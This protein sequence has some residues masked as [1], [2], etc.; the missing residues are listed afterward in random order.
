MTVALWGSPGCGKTTLALRMAAGLSRTSTVAVLFCDTLVP[1]LPVILPSAGRNI[2]SV[3]GALSSVEISGENVLRYANAVP[4][5][6]NVVLFGFAPG[7]NC[8]SYPVFGE[9]RAASFIAALGGLCEYLIIDCMAAA[10]EDPL[11]LAA[12][13]VSD[14]VVRVYSPDMSSIVFYESNLRLFTD[15]GFDTGRHV[16]VLNIPDSEIA[17]PVGETLAGMK[18]CD[19]VFPHIRAIKQSYAEGR[20]F[21]VPPSR[22]LNHA[23]DMLCGFCRK[24]DNVRDDE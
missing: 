2:L 3:G 5:N 16:R 17:R 21:D 14:R 1:P 11:C 18:R 8:R 20:A 6:G 13:R 9:G 12:L 7:E 22:R 24:E 10:S 4:S 15:A 23:T 19:Y